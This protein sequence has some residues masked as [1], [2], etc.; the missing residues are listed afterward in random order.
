TCLLLPGVAAAALSTFEPRGIEINLASRSAAD[1]IEAPLLENL[2]KVFARAGASFG[3]S[4]VRTFHP[5]VL[6]GREAAPRLTSEDVA[7]IQSSVIAVSPQWVAILSIVFRPGL[8]PGEREDTKP[9]HLLVKNVLSEIRGGARLRDTYRGLVNKLLEPGLKRYAAL[10]THSFNVAR[11]A[12]KLAEECGLS[13]T[14][15]EQITVAAVLHDVGMRDLAYDELYAKRSL[16]EDELRLVKEHPRAGA[17]LLEDV[18]FP[19]PIAPLVRH[20]HERWDGNGYPAGLRGETIPF[21]ARLIHLCEAWDA[22]TSPTTYR[23][24]LTTSQAAEILIE[25]RGTQFD[26]ELAPLF[27]RIVGDLNDEEN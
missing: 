22:M 24:V 14:E 7:A 11:L 13:V 19:Y 9:I 5:I 12:R 27:V 15:T 17:F 6:P 23:S 2:A 21:G 10:R 4:G 18:A 8:Q 1:E 3:F 20:H 16:S 25:K 26:P